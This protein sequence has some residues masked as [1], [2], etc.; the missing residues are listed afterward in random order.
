M[1]FSTPIRKLK[2][3]FTINLSESWNKGLS[4]VNKVMNTTQSLTHS[5]TITLDNRKKDKWDLRTS[6]N[7]AYTDARFSLDAA[8]NNTYYQHNWF[9]EIAFTPSN[10]ISFMASA[11]ITSYKG[12]RFKN[13]VVI[14]L[15]KAEVRYYFL[16]NNRGILSLEA[17]D[18][19]N[20]NTG[21][22]RVS[23]LNYLMERHS[24]IIQQYFLLSFKFKLNKFDINEGIN[25]DIKGPR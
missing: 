5:A 23:E 20:K 18:L 15:L 13:S 8:L 1:D 17:F 25:I 14:P 7:I 19:L 6:Y 24:T 10:R 21:I 2:L 16:K 4:L 22:Q 11:D 9:T 12:S 3:N